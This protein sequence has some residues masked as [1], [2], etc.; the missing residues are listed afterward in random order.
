MTEE[1]RSAALAE[2]A[3]EVAEDIDSAKWL[4][5]EERRMERA[6]CKHEWVVERSCPSDP[7]MIC[8]KCGQLG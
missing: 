1:E 6:V 5:E 3:A 2:V 7:V 8:E 4:V